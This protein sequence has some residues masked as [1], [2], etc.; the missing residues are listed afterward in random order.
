MTD[1]QG[2]RQRVTK[3]GEEAIGKFAR[4]LGEAARRRV[5]ERYDWEAVTSRYLALCES[6]LAA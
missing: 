4:A 3:Q 5:Q 2:L 1:E 6:S